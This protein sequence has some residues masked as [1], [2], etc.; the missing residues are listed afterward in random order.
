MGSGCLVAGQLE[1]ATAAPTRHEADEQIEPESR[2]W[3]HG[4]TCTHTQLLIAE[5]A[6]RGTDN[7]HHAG[8][9]NVPHSLP[10]PG[11]AMYS[12]HSTSN[13]SGFNNALTTDLALPGLDILSL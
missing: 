7:L 8:D 9:G 1:L 5:V 11:V 6:Q 10:V 2:S 12:G 3:N 13:A 4:R